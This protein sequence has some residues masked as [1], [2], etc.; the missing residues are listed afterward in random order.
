MGQQDGT[1]DGWSKF[2]YGEYCINIEDGPG[3][4]IV[5]THPSWGAR[6]IIKVAGAWQTRI[7][8]NYV[9]SVGKYMDGLIDGGG[10]THYGI[11]VNGYS[12][13]TGN[14]VNDNAKTAQSDPIVGY[15]LQDGPLIWDNNT[16]IANA[17]DDAAILEDHSAVGSVIG[18]SVFKRS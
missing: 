10:I 5:N 12:I 6:D 13:T 4:S 14:V 7:I 1:I 16:M 3:W 17:G 11:N 15:R 8:G 18:S 9:G 2:Q